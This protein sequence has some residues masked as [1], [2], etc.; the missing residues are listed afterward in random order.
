ME[1]EQRKAE[2]EL[3]MKQMEIEMMQREIEQKRLRAKFKEAKDKF[4][5]KVG[6]DFLP[7]NSWLKF[8]EGLD[9]CY[10]IIWTGN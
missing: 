10:M 8:A 5:S 2:M 7:R 1:M 4:I 3:E 6:N 9:H